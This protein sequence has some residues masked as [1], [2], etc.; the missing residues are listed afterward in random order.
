ME[1][2]KNTQEVKEDIVQFYKVTG[3]GAGRPAFHHLHE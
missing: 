2:S 3:Y 1:S